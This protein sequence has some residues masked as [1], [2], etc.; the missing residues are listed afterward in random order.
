VLGIYLVSTPKPPR[1][2]DMEVSPPLHAL[3]L[4]LQESNENADL[5]FEEFMRDK[6]KYWVSADTREYDE[7]DHH[8]ATR[9][10]EGQE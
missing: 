1:T 6:A 3:L 4:P 8:R 2:E 5:R 10:P 9:M 7:V